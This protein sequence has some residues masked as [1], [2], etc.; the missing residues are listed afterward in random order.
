[1]FFLQTLSAIFE[2]K[3]RSAPFLPGFSGILLRFAANQNFWGALAPPSPT[4]LLFI[5]ALVISWFIKIDLKHIYCSYSGTKKI[6]NDS[7]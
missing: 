5:A 2:I 1:V 4:P 3:Q 7:L 6:Q